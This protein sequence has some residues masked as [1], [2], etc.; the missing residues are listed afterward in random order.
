MRTPLCAKAVVL[1]Q[2]ACVRS[3]RAAH[4][5]EFGL[6]AVAATLLLE[7]K[8]RFAARRRLHRHAES[9]TARVRNKVEQ[10]NPL[11]A[12][13]RKMV[14]VFGLVSGPQ[15]GL[16]IGSIRAKRTVLCGLCLSPPSGSPGCV[17]SPR[18][19]VKADSASCQTRQFI[20]YHVL[21]LS[22]VRLESC[23]CDVPGGRKNRVRGQPAHTL[24]SARG[25]PRLVPH[26]KRH[27]PDFA[28]SA[29]TWG[30]KKWA[31]AS[32]FAARLNVQKMGRSSN[33]GW[34]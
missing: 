17:S 15:C 8:V 22:C 32:L 29:A 6:F 18:I 9:N 24:T 11:L 12:K 16:E 4:L 19:C 3:R 33:S 26:C 27:G 21:R 10:P 28:D 20:T 2:C 31:F 7:N 30:Y 23:S 1:S 14:Q 34:L 13:N 5:C 25:L